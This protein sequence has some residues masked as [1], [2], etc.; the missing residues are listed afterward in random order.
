M[1]LNQIDT[2]MPCPDEV[3]SL[4]KRIAE[5]DG[6]SMMQYIS[7]HCWTLAKVLDRLEYLENFERQIKEIN[8]DI[9]EKLSI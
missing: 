2:G 4:K 6:A 8:H 9:Y 1:M 7:V 5:R 3:N